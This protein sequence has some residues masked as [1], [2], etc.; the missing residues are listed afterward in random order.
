MEGNLAVA[1]DSLAVAEEGTL[2]GV[3]TEEEAVCHSS[4]ASSEK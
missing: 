1:E 3:G 2:P 4:L